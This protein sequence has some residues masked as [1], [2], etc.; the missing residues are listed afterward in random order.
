MT[1]PVLVVSRCLDLEPVRYNGDVVSCSF[2]RELR[3]YV[4]FVPVCPEIEIGLG[5][6]RDPVRIEMEK[7]MPRLVQP[8]TG[9]DL[10]E[11][12]VGF[13]ARFL[14]SLDAVDGFLLKG[15]SPSCALFDAKRRPLGKPGPMR[16]GPGLFGASVLERFGG[17]AVED[18][19]RLRDFRIREHFLTKLFGLARLREVAATER[20]GELVRFHSE[21]KLLLLAHHQ[22]KLRRMGRLVAL[23]ASAGFEDTIRRYR[24]LFSEALAHRARFPSV[25]NVLEHAVGYFKKQLD[26]R[27][28]AFY[29]RMLARYRDGRVPVSGVTSIL[30]AWITRFQESYL[31]S[32]TFFQPFPEALMGLTSLSD[33]GKGGSERMPPG[34]SRGF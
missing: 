1:V 12:M 18:E 27:E 10:T 24:K 5:V 23:S 34:N 9:R 7:A 31:A 26:P 11:P 21:N 2:V 8:T 16:R 32:Q 6:P 22:E 28:K 30:L 33:S 15:R 19:G 4:R 29:R 14:G 25:V 13:A 3:P 20:I 17:L